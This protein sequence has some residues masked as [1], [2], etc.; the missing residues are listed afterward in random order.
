MFKLDKAKLIVFRTWLPLA[1]VTT[2]LG[3]LIYLVVQQDLRIGANDPQIQITEDVASELASGQNFQ[4]FIP[5]TKIDMSKSLANYIMIFDTNGKLVGSSVSLDGKDPVLPQGAFTSTK[6]NPTN[7]AR[8]TWQP[9]T[10]VRSAVVLDY[11]KGQASGFVLVGRSLREV[12]IREDR[13]ELIV[14][15]GWS[16]TMLLSLLSV[17]AIRK[18]K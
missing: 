5:P 16:V 6:Q 12:E 4:Y 7:E 11:Y 15:A 2:C 9:K 17:F 10:G 8:F 13:L 18:F 14:F 1:I 3:G